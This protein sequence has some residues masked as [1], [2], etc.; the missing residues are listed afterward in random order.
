MSDIIPKTFDVIYSGGTIVNQ[1]GTGIT[2]VGIRDGRIAAVGDLSKADAGE[3]IDVTGLHV[4]PGVID[5]QVHMREPGNEH[6]EDLEAGGNAAVL[7]GVTAVFEMPNT[8]P[9]TTNSDALA[10]KVSRAHHRMQCDYAFYAGATTENADILA[11]LEREPGCCGVKIFMGSSTGNLLVPDDD[12]VRAVLRAIN[13]R[14]AV[15]SED[16]YRLRERRE[17]AEL[18]KPET[19]PVWRDVQ[20]AVQCTERLLRLAREEGARI[21]VLHITTA[22][23]MPILAANKD[24]A[25]VE[26]TPQHLT[27]AAPDC[28]QEIGTRALM[29]PPIRTAEHRAGLW[30]GIAA[31][32]VDI[33]ATDHSP[34]TLEEKSQAYPKAPSGMPGVQTFVPVMLNY[35]NEGKLSL[36][37]FV[38]LTSHGPNRVFGTA[39]K[40]RIA[41]G[42]DADLTIVD[43]K[44]SRTIEDDWIA[45]VS[46]WSAFSGRTMTGWPIGTVIRGRKVMWDDEIIGKA[47]GEPVTFTEVLPR[48]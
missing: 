37:R 10:D 12:H 41:V 33:V 29:N 31:G 44:K 2:D 15:H 25:T 5:T 21:H 36:E 6:K 46:K 23:E 1:D 3:R 42:Y 14:C 18:D 30:A 26:V 28:Y 19:H 34:H 43:M 27:F 11:D 4:L 38:D 40:G 48:G 22:D 17:L 7:G 47:G 9:P 16:E 13:R 20:T 35:V 32:I 24:I 45:S 8:K 39:R